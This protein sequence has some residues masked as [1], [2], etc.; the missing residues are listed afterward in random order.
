MNLTDNQFEDLLTVITPFAIG[1]LEDVVEF[2]NKNDE[3]R[4]EVMKVCIKSLEVG[5]VLLAKLLKDD[6]ID[7]SQLENLSSLIREN[8][9]QE[10]ADIINKNNE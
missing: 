10:A 6:A 9:L 5:V 3:Q 7:L 2:E 4:E 1:E 8:K